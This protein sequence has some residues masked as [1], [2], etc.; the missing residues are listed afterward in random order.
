MVEDM[1][2]ELCPDLV[3][4]RIDRSGSLKYES[5]PDIEFTD[6]PLLRVD[7]KSTIGHF[8][9]NNLTK[10]VATCKDKYGGTPV[11]IFGERKGKTK[12]IRDNIGVAIEHEKFGI[13]CLQLTKWLVYLNE[14]V[15]TSTQT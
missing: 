15:R 14:R 6:F 4:N 11:I 1:A 3:V 10:L 2:H 13:V 9:F 7:C 5:L 8:S 12:I